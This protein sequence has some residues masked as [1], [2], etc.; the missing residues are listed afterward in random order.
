MRTYLKT[1]PWLKFQVDL[2]QLKYTIW[3]ALGEAQ[4]KCEHISGVPLR[5]AVA[6]QL[7]KLFLAKGVLATT[8]I[9][10]N[11]LTESEVLQHLEGKLKLPPSK[12]YL[13]KEIDNIIEACDLIANDI[14]VREK[15][16]ISVAK[17]ENY[18]KLVL[19]DLS[20]GD[21][22]V[23]GKIREFSVGVGRY[24][25]A[26]AEDCLYLLGKLCSW[27]NEMPIPEDNRIVFGLLKAIIAHIYFVWIHP[28]G[29][30]NGRT[31]RL[32][33][34]QIL[35]EA[36]IPTPAAH[37]LSNFYNLTRAEYY[38]QLD[39]TSKTEGNLSDFI[40]YAIKGYVDELKNQ[41]NLIRL[42]QWDIVWR[43]YVHELFKDK[44]SEAAVRQRHLA[45]DLSLKGEEPVRAAK[46]PEISPRMAAAYATKTRKT[47]ARDINNLIEM[48]LVER[49]K[50]GIRSKREVILAFLP[51]RK[52]LD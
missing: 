15:S 30:G 5:P 50:D 25:A 27:L 18:N 45:L 52:F 13:S 33:E 39:K 36:G 9:E 1:H 19:K 23:P 32:I 7:H 21:Q 37:L 12:E 31:A 22:I 26:P 20:L 4:S 47:M 16:E 10:G 11:T 48:D 46:I 29:D 17:I 8:A 41:I 43:N 38:R 3:T 44:A 49:T 51:D 42:Q 28:F 6:R 40:E 14:I 24:K 2:R 35:L 34:F